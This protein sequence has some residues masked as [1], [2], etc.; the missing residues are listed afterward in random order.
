MDP[1]VLVLESNFFGFELLDIYES[2]TKFT[3]FCSSF[4]LQHEEPG[5]NSPDVHFE[6]VVKL[7]PVET[8]TLEEDEEEI[9]KM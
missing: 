9:F 7:A 8:I 5:P 2:T 3:T 1:E 4:I 6:P